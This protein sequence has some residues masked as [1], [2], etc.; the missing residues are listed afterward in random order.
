MLSLVTVFP[1]S[2]CFCLLVRMARWPLILLGH[3]FSYTTSWDSTQLPKEHASVLTKTA[4]PNNAARFARFIGMLA[5]VETDVVDCF[6]RGGGVDY[7]AYSDFMGLWSE[8]VEEIHGSQLIEKVVPL[9]P[10]IQEALTRGINVLDVGCGDGTVVN[11]LADAFPKSHFA[12]WD[13][14]EGP[15]ER[16]KNKSTSLG[17]NNTQFAARDVLQSDGEGLFDFVT[18]FDCIHD[19]AQPHLTLSAIRR[20]LKTEGTFLMVDIA[21]SSELQNN[22][23]NPMAPW[24]YTSSCLHCMTVSLAQGGAGLGSMWG[25]EK[26]VELLEETGFRNIV[27]EKLDGAIFNNYFIST[28]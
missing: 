9:M 2:P 10:D 21:A 16:A 25:D 27:V 7:S 6:E 11:L 3:L 12:G 15:I 22:L 14:L 20:L 4:G 5:K 24:L 13:I 19:M 8:V 28:A 1:P 26:A 23:N 18:A 17:F